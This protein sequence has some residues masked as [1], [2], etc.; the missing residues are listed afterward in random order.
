IPMAIEPRGCVASYHAG[1]GALTLWTSTQIPH[2]I[3]TLLPAMIGVPENKM[4]IVA[5]EVGGGFGAKL[6]LYAEEALVSH[7]A[8]RLNAPVK[9]IESRRENAA[10][11]I[12]G[13]DQ[14]GEYEVA[15][16]NDGSILGLKARTV[17]DLGA[18]CQLLT[19]AIPTLTGL[20]LSGCY[21][22]PAVK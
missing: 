10:A 21:R 20:V 17:A 18:Y 22:I 6:N 9:W 1:E 13:R 2:L 7:L 3:R 16:K 11:T 14:V 5:P 19:P 4:R 15:V 8:M 12:H